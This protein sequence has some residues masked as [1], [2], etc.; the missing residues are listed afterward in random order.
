MTL[1]AT[2]TGRKTP[3]RLIFAMG[4]FVAL[5]FALTMAF[6]PHPPHVMGNMWDKEQH[7]LAFATLSFLAAF[8]FPAMPLPRIAERLSFIGALIEV[9][10]SYPPLHRDCDIFDWV[11][12]TAAVILMLV[13]VKLA[14]KLLKWDTLPPAGLAQ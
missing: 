3:L 14:V 8:G 7:M 13:V 4:F 5:A 9:V 11:A 6:L 12:D 2:P 10:Q 1:Y